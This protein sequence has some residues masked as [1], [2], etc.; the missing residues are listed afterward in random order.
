MQAGDIPSKFNIPFA[1]SAGVGYKRVVPQNSQIGINDGWASLTDGFPP[2]NF[3]PLGS[4]GV[5]PFGQ[6]MNGLLNQITLWSRWQ[7][8]GALP[9][10]DAGFST[11][12]GGYPRGAI[13]SATLLQGAWLCLVDNN[14]VNPDTAPSAI[15]AGW[16]FLGGIQPLTSNVTFYVNTATGSDTYDGTSPTHVSG[17]VGPFATIQKAVNVAAQFAPSTFGV[18]VSVASGTYAAWSTPNWAHANVT[19][20]G[21][22]TGSTTITSASSNTININGPNNYT[23]TNF[24]CSNTSGAFNTPVIS[25]NFAAQTT[26]NNIAFGSSPNCNAIYAFAG[27]TITV[28]AFSI[29]GNFLSILSAGGAGS[30]IFAPNAVCN[31]G[32]TAVSGAYA[33]AGSL[34][35]I[36]TTSG[37]ATMAFV[38]PG[39]VTGSKYS[40]TFN[41]I[42]GTLTGNVNYFPGSSAGATSTGGQ[43]N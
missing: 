24:T 14:T 23:L 41:A 31:C 5:P 35:S 29:V 22:G 39:N 2:L 20:N 33:T 16:L 42:I 27:G 32:I 13:L 7:A 9:Q 15:Q 21:A 36:G 3:Q 6:D 19:V 10:Y 4:G 1:N 38:N 37:A 40:V 34:G 12:I 8:A 28:G 11:A 43:Y 26:I 17:T 30:S 18:T 25:S